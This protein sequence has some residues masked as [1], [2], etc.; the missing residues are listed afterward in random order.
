MFP[1]AT[2]ISFYDLLEEGDIL[3]LIKFFCSEM[4]VNSFQ[5]SMKDEVNSIHLI[6]IKL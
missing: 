3:D 4:N 6:Y 5:M 2:K 1:Y